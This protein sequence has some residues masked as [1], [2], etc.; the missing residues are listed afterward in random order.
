MW[1]EAHETWLWWAGSLSVAVFLGSLVVIPWVIVRMPADYFSSAR[2]E[3]VLR[4]AGRRSAWRWAVLVAK[5]LGG[6][7]LMVAGLAML[8]LPGQGL[9]TLLMGFLLL[10]FPGKYRMERWLVQRTPLRRIIDRCRVRAG[11]EPLR[12]SRAERRAV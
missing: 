12:I 7:L 6:G 5:N 1:A 4:E 2:R 9:L 11:R 8:V 10:D 3:R